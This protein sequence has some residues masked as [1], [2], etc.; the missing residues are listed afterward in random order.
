MRG[1]TDGSWDLFHYGHL[2]MLQACADQ[3]D[4]LIVGVATQRLHK[5]KKGEI[6]VIPFRERMA[7]ISALRCVDRAIP[8]DSLGVEDYAHWMPDIRFIGG[9][10]GGFGQAQADTLKWCEENGIQVVKI[11]RTIGVSTS[12]LKRELCHRR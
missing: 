12:M 10:Y 9:D 3:C 8:H 7:I 11:P 6:P 2:K 1:Y 5:L 4:E